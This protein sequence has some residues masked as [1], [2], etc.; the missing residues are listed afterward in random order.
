MPSSNA[1]ALTLNYGTGPAMHAYYANYVG[2]G[3]LGSGFTAWCYN[4]PTSMPAGR[5]SPVKDGVGR[6]PTSCTITTPLTTLGTGR[7]RIDVANGAT[8]GD[9][10]VTVQ[11]I[12]SNAMCFEE[13]TTMVGTALQSVV[14]CVNPADGANVDAKFAWFYRTDSLS[15]PQDWPN[16]LLKSAYARVNLSGSLVSSQSFNPMTTHTVSAAR[17]SGAAVGRFRVTFKDLNPL[18]GSVDP[19]TLANDIIVTKTCDGD[20]N[21]A[22][23]R[24][25]C[26]AD[27]WQS[28]TFSNADTTVDV[29][30]F[31]RDGNYRDTGFRV[32]AGSESFSD[33]AWSAGGDN[34]SRDYHFGWANLTNYTAS[35]T[36]TLGVTAHRNQHESPWDDYPSLATQV[37]R[38]GTGR[39]TADF[40]GTF[41]HI[42]DAIPIVTSR[43]GSAIASSAA[44]RG[45]YCNVWQVNSDPGSLDIRCYN[46]GGGSQ[47]NV[48]WN[49]SVVY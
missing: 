13:S 26:V 21:A 40:S 31:D 10:F 24:S 46:R 36:Q 30:C 44:L 28:G 47:V 41:Y 22:C 27:S 14:R 8:L 37:T 25:V 12:G 3:N 49:V 39:Y 45:S 20:S 4:K 34:N 7:Y 33:Q 11:T 35:G 29:S 6:P 5:Q 43:G 9:Y 48:P 2:N 32:F 16:Y 23:S 19:N 17:I 18:D 38:S 15:Y 42:D 1:S